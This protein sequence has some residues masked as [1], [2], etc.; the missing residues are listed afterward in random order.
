MKDRIQKLCKRLNRFTLEEIALIAEIEESEIK[1][2]LQDLIKENLLTVNDNNYIYNNIEKE[3]KL[4][5]RLPKMFE[6]HSQETIDMIINCFCAEIPPNKSCLILNPH[7]SRICNFN[8]FFRQRLYEKQYEELLKF[9]NA[10]PQLPRNRM[11]FDKKMYFYTYNNKVYVSDKLLPCD[12]I[13]SFSPTE[14][15]Q[16]RILY[17]FLIRRVKHNTRKKYIH[18][19]I[20]EQIWRHKKE[21]NFLK[22]DLKNLLL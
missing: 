16:F 12:T 6:Y 1:I 14:E 18:F 20:A 2:I 21:Y 19:H 17:S 9:F 10:K 5:K 13:E 3:S 15:K 11:F 22:S 8:L 4:I 7:E